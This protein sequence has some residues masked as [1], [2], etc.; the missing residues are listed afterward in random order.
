MVKLG[1][2]P[3]V[4]INRVTVRKGKEFTVSIDNP[5]IL[6]TESTY[7]VF[8]KVNMDDKGVFGGNNVFDNFA[9]QPTAGQEKVEAPSATTE[10]TEQTESAEDL[11]EEGLSAENIKMV[12]E[13]TKCTKA[14]AIKALRESGD[15]SVNA[16]MKITGWFLFQ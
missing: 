3:V 14:A 16:I 1:L 13:Y 4:G 11:N 15:D 9:Q 2:K 12:M 6:Q 5:D 8:G 10:Q 7:V